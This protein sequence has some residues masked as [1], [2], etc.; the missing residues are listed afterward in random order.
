MELELALAG[1]QQLLNGGDNVR[2]LRRDLLKASFA[3]VGFWLFGRM[4]AAKAFA[5]SYV[6]VDTWGEIPENGKLYFSSPV[7]IAK[8]G[9]GNIYVSDLG[10]CRIVKLS[11][12][13]HVLN[14]FGGL[15]SSPG[16][17]DLPF[18][19]EIDNAG[20]ILVTDAANSR[21]Q[22]FNSNFE[23]VC[24]W[25]SFGARDGEF[26]LPNRIAA[27][28]DNNYYVADEFNNRIQKFDESGAFL[29]KW[30]EYGTNAGQ[31]RLPQGISVN[32]NGNI[33]VVDT[34][35]DRVQEFTQDGIFVSEFGGY[36]YLPGQL[37]HP[38]GIDVDPWG[39]V[40]VVECYN[41]RIQKFNAYHLPVYV[42]G[43]FPY[44]A[45]PTAVVWNNGYLYVSDTANNRIAVFLDNGLSATLVGY[46]GDPR[47]ENGQFAGPFGVAVDEYDRVYI[48][49]SFN[50][51][52]QVFDRQGNLLMKIGKN[53]GEGG[54]DGYG[55][56]PGEFFVPRQ[57][58]AKDGYIYVAD[59]FNHRIQVFDY[60]GNF[61]AAFGSYG[62]L[63]GQFRYPVGVAVDDSGNVYVSDTGNNRIQ[64]FDSH[65]NF[66]C[67]WG[68]KGCGD[69]EF[70]Q[71]MELAVDENIFVV[72]RFNNRIQKFD[73]NGAFL[74]KWGTNGGSGGEDY[75]LNS[76]SKPGEFFLPIGIAVDAEGNVYVSDSSNN[77]IQ[78]FT[79]DGDFICE[80]GRFS[81]TA[82]NF[83]SPM[84]I[85][86]DSAGY[87]YVADGILNRIQVFAPVG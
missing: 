29:L 2:I 87:L 49:D 18:G 79:N 4:P 23:F 54:P 65:F 78:K 19:V 37:N 82:G 34:H 53:N 15:G 51:R 43:S 84:G 42:V 73:E 40:F 75:I 22:K 76:G 8:D 77:R 47:N 52:I 66:V 31:F 21:V 1:V 7:G 83:F 3:A 44:L 41:H 67:C 35:N 20:N 69:G 13:G 63:L 58:F 86:V 6:H 14:K 27:D 36:G 38:R 17:F 68:G 10:N 16:K 81:A 33:L 24:E 5:S 60:H 9:Q 11:P 50:H 72:D 25:G 55:I 57:V 56:L 61:I 12:Q 74:L 62:T 30:G 26:H 64:K 48:S 28:A 39:N 71:P 80:F 45:F 32:V 85:G 46:I 59:S 70:N